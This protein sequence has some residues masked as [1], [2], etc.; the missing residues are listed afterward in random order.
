MPTGDRFTVSLDTEL[1][2][3]FDAH[4][5][6]R[7][8]ENRSEAIRD[9]IR[10]ALLEPRLTAGDGVAFCLLTLL[11]DHRSPR[12]HDRLRLVLLEASETVVNCTSRPVSRDAEAVVLTLRGTPAAV[13]QVIDGVRAIRGL[14]HCRAAIVPG[15]APD[16]HSARTDNYDATGSR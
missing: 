9:L 7:G 1:L 2:A 15:V 11:C 5:A 4:L 10:D 8:Y 6:A 16:A 13:Q 12:A 3:A 14:T